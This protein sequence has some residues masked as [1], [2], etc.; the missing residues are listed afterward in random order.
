MKHVPWQ[1]GTLLE[2]LSLFAGKRSVC[3]G[4]GLPRSS[5][6]H[7][8]CASQRLFQLAESGAKPFS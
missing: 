2:V 4:A 8:L 1:H 3:A 6:V 7:E 5:G